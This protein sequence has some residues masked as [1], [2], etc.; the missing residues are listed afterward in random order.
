M[1]LRV[2]TIKTIYDKKELKEMSHARVVV[3]KIQKCGGR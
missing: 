3:A 2:L 1:L